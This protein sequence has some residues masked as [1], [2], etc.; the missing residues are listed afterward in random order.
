[1]SVKNTVCIVDCT[2]YRVKFEIWSEIVSRIVR[3]L[4]IA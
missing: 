3:L 2:I 4:E 1:M